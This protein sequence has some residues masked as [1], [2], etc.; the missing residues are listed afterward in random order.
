MQLQCYRSALRTVAFARV[1]FQSVLAIASLTLASAAGAQKFPGEQKPVTAPVEDQNLQSWY[2]SP[3]GAAR[4]TVPTKPVSPAQQEALKLLT[5]E[6][7]TPDFRELAETLVAV[8]RQITDHPDIQPLRHKA[9]TYLYLIGDI[10][11]ALTELKAA[12]ALEPGDPIVRAQLAKALE[13]AGDDRQ[14]L[15]EFRQALAT[16][17][18][19]AEVHFEFAEALMHNYNLS[20]AVNE[21]R[22]A[23]QL[24]PTSDAFAVLS[25]ALLASNDTA[26]AVK[27]ARRAVSTNP[28]SARAQIALTNALIK[29]GDVQS[30]QR[31]ARQATLLNPQAP[32]SHLAMGRCLYHK[33]EI[34]QA[35]DEFK[36][37]VAL[38]PLSCQAR[39]DLGYALYKRGDMMAAITEFRLA[40]RI[41]PRMSEARNN[42]EVAVHRLYSP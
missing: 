38:D 24:K 33:G 5:M 9:G 1:A 16:G 35:V 19:I 8:R 28:S 18:H 41:N 15:E 22:Q 27:I 11:G 30:A 39:N 12:L 14:A 26:S 20:D 25:E 10:Q 3:T 21:Y 32:E 23:C 6:A 42:L 29:Q 40:L 37:A 34:A 13:L 2:Q 17:G 4:S 31:T 36:Q 7:Q